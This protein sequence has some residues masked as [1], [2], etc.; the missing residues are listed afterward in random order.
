MRRKTETGHV[1]AAA[2][3]G[4]IKPRRS[5]PSVSLPDYMEA[6]SAL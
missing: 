1:H 2:K 4:F 5:L 3:K 6:W